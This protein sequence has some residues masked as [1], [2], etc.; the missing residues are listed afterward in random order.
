[1]K[2]LVFGPRDRYDVYRPDFASGLPVE[3]VFCR[4]D[5][6]YLQA[7]RANPDARV[8]L[9]DAISVVEAD[10]MDALPELKL[11]HSEGVGYNGIDCAAARERGIFVCNNKGCNAASVAEHAIMLM[12]MALRCG[13]SGH[14]AVLEGRQM[15]VKTQIFAARRPGLFQCTVGLVGLGDIGSA[16]ARRLAAFGCAVFYNSAH[17]RSPEEERELG[18]A[19]LS[20]EELCARC[21]IVSLHCAVTDRTRGMVDAAFLARMK[22]TAILVNTARG[23][24]VDNLALRRALIEGRIGGA[25]LDTVSPEPVP[26][27]HPLV[28]LPA[29]ARER[30]V[31]SPHLGGTSS[32]CSQRAHRTMWSNMRLLLEGRRPEYVVNGL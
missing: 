3:L 31:H 18:V 5:Q 23:D 11:I 30:V 32:G 28:D 1:M 20:L 7:A 25:A 26:A 6:T 22:P 12:L 24:L 16:V 29:G 15:E 17:R 8:I 27:D 9:A 2:A 10:V 4:E 19:W 21:D 13:L 14:Q